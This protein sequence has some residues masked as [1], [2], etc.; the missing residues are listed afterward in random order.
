MD[1]LD[2]PLRVDQVCNALRVLVGNRPGSAVCETEVP[3]TVGDEW[4][5]EPLLVG[6]GAARVGGVEADAD[7][8]GA[9]LPVFLVSVPEPETLGRSP[10]GVGFREE[11]QD[12]PLASQVAQAYGPPK[13]IGRVE[14]GR[15]LPRLEH[16]PAPADCG[17]GKANDSLE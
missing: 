14:V 13:M 16:P 1:L 11:P 8:L 2:A 6:E 9:E 10:G 17:E 7:D 12:D 5:G 15:G 4:E 3:V